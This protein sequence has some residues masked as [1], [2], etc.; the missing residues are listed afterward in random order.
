[1]NETV[2]RKMKVDR[3]VDVWNK[4]LWTATVGVARGEGE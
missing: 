2:D 1:M 3:R 4:R